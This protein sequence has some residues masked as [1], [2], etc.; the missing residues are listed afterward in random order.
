M[1]RRLK[2]NVDHWVS[3]LED[4]DSDV[5]SRARCAR[6][7]QNI[8]ANGWR[9]GP[10]QRTKLAALFTLIEE[11]APG[12][13]A[14]ASTAELYRLATFVVRQLA[15]AHPLDAEKIDV[16]E[17]VGTLA[18]WTVDVDD[19]RKRG[20]RRKGRVGKWN[21]LANAIARTSFKRSAGTLSKEHRNWAPSQRKQGSE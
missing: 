10:L 2:Y 18:E 9:D 17:L 6:Y 16:P 15:V 13:D 12:R 20:G 8:M 14:P 3:V 4:P 7:V 1:A 11:V 5:A 19:P 21:H